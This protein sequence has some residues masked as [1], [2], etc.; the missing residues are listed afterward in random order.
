VADRSELLKEID[1]TR[2]RV[3]GAAQIALWFFEAQDFAAT[4]RTL[5]A[6][7]DAHNAALHAYR[8]ALRG[9]EHGNRSAA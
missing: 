4:E 6:A 8:N 2:A 3:V 9:E 5:R 1:R 7:L